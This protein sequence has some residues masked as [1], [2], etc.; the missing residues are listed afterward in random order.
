MY[1]SYLK[2]TLSP[3]MLSLSSNH[4]SHITITNIMKKCEILWEHKIGKCYWK[5]GTNRLVWFRGPQNVQFVK[6]AKQ[7]TI[8]Q[9]M[10]VCSHQVWKVFDH[11][12]F[13]FFF[14]LFLHLS[15]LSVTPKSLVF[16]FLKL[17]NNFLMSVHLFQSFS[18]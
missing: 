9:G 10:P 7:S 11:D 13:R 14:F 3:K 4:W 2:N 17:S 1:I 8:K 6:N 18:V 15:L 12:F 16:G 5:N